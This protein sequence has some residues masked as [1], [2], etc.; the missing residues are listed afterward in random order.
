MVPQR[1][2]LGS[3]LRRAPRSSSSQQWQASMDRPPLRLRCTSRGEE[4]SST[5]KRSSSK[6]ANFHLLKSIVIFGRDSLVNRVVHSQ[7]YLRKTQ[8]WAGVSGF[9]L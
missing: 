3:E 9:Q 8:A 1:V 5:S 6:V 7:K 4:Y 2:E